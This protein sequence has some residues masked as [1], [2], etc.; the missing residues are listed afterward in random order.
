M[1]G[2]TTDVIVMIHGTEM[3]LIAEADAICPAEP[4]VGIMY[5]SIEGWDL[6]FA[7]GTPIPSILYAFITM[8]EQ[9]KISDALN[10]AL[11][12]GDFDPDH[13]I[14]REE[15]DER[16]RFAAQEESI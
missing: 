1:T 12:R 10:D 9:I 15:R 6:L 4:D 8:R 14:L 7:D 2:L 16:R 11:S 3:E 5:P 13:N